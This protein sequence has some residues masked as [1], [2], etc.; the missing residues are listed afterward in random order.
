MNLEEKIKQQ[1]L[2]FLSHALR[3][4]QYKQALFNNLLNFKYQKQEIQFVEKYL[5]CNNLKIKSFIIRFLCKNGSSLNNFFK[6]LDE[7]ESLL[8][9]FIQIAYENNDV[10]CLLQLLNEQNGKLLDVILAIKKIG[11]NDL[12]TSLMFSDNEEIV[13]LVRKVINNE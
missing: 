7:D 10:D 13:D 11:R 8:D 12:L 4:Q 1:N 5:E 3:K 6:Y 2:K 9:E